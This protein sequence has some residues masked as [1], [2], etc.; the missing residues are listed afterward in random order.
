MGTYLHYQKLV[1]AAAGGIIATLLV[2]TVARAAD[3]K[4]QTKP[5]QQTKVNLVEGP[6]PL[7]LRAAWGDTFKEE[8][9]LRR[10]LS[11]KTKR[12]AIFST[13]VYTAAFETN[14]G[15]L[16]ISATS[17]PTKDCESQANVGLSHNLVTCPMRV[18][19]ISGDNVKIIFAEDDF[20]LAD[21]GDQGPTVQADSTKTAVGTLITFDPSV[22]TLSTKLFLG[23]DRILSAGEK[24]P[25]DQSISLKF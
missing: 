22:L 3:D 2:S 16:V 25:N 4:I 18:A 1:S 5:L 7:K 21:S 13:D 15:Q 14:G 6:D 17:T 24:D 8:V 11:E 23:G 19:F 20:A 12:P 9:A 10:K